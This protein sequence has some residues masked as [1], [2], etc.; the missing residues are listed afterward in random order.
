M[1]PHLL[2]QQRH[3]FGL[4]EGVIVGDVEADDAP[5]L[6]V[7]AE[8]ALEFGAVGALHDEDQVGLVEVVGRDR[9][10]RI[11]RQAGGGGLDAG[12]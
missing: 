7:F 3:Q 5:A 9:L 8:A 2:L 10:L 6:Q 1:R 4:H 12:A 11:G